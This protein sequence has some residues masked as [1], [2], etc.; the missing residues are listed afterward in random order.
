MLDGGHFWL[1]KTPTR[2]GSH[3]WGALFPRM[4]TWV[5]LRPR[6]GASPT[7]YWF[8]TH[9][10][11]F[12]SKART[13]SAYM[14]NQ[15]MDKIAGQSARV[16]SG[17][18]NADAGSVPYY[19]LVG[20]HRNTPD[21]RLVDSFRAANPRPLKREEG[22]MHNFSGRRDGQRID[23]I[24]ATPQFQVVEASIDRARGNLG[25]PSDHFPV[26]ATLRPTPIRTFAQAE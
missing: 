18:F 13:E 14:L 4:V 26:T 16:L 24:F 12:N 2:A 17:D 19:M 3:G 11:A 10:D 15:W 9:F 21:Y 22:T 7:F 5:K 20:S 1:S 6:D 25:Y 23:W 8:N